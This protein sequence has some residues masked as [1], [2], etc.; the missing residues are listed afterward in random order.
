VFESEEFYVY[1]PYTL[2]LRFEYQEKKCVAVAFANE[3]VVDFNSKVYTPLF[4]NVYND[5]ESPKRYLWSVCEGLDEDAVSLK[6]SIN[7][8]WNTRF[9]T[10]GNTCIIRTFGEKKL[11]GTYFQYYR[12]WEQ[13][14]EF[15]LPTEC[16]REEFERYNLN[17]FCASISKENLVFQDGFKGNGFIQNIN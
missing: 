10:D 7:R 1:F 12:W 13:L 15:K 8:F 3:P 14:G 5:I 2:F 17:D 6:D 11:G 4:T 16:H 9:G